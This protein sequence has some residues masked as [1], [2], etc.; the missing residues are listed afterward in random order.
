MARY[1]GLTFK[2]PIKHCASVFVSHF[3]TAYVST[4][5]FNGDFHCWCVF[6]GHIMYRLGET[7]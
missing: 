5:F 4:A 2:T 7:A 6:M 1:S 3:V